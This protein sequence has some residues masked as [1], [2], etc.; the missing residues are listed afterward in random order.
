MSRPKRIVEEKTYPEYRTHSD[1]IIDREQRYN[2][3]RIERDISN[4]NYMTKDT[5]KLGFW[6]TFGITFFMLSIAY[7][8][9]K[10]HLIVP[11]IFI[12]FSAI[13]ILIIIYFLFWLWKQI[14]NRKNDKRNLRR[15]S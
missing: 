2:K 4:S 6:L 1:I 9:L 10:Y 11:V 15:T 13:I 14:K 12:G 8:I 5:T 3:W 7:V